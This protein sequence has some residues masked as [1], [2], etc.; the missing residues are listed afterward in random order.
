MFNRGTWRLLNFSK[1]ILKD[2]NALARSVS[3]KKLFDIKNFRL[4]DITKQELE[5]LKCLVK[6][7][8]NTFTE[9][10]EIQQLKKV[11]SNSEQKVT[12]T[13]SRVH[14]VKKEIEETKKKLH[15]ITY[16]YNHYLNKVER[17][18]EDNIK[19]EQ[20]TNTRAQYRKHVND[21]RQDYAGKMK[22][23]SAYLIGYQTN[24]TKLSEKETSWEWKTNLKGWGIYALTIMINMIISFYSR[25]RFMKLR[26]SND[27]TEKE[28]KDKYFIINLVSELS[29]YYEK[30]NELDSLGIDEDL[31]KATNESLQ[32]L[33]EDIPPTNISTLHENKQENSSSSSSSTSSIVTK[34]SM[35]STSENIK[36]SSKTQ[37]INNQSNLKQETPTTLESIETE[38]QE[39]EWIFPSSSTL[40]IP[41]I[42]VIAQI[43]GFV[44]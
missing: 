3:Y 44:L 13:M 16:D 34:S 30:I 40:Y 29:K 20:L 23:Q 25:K 26:A 10:D 38:V 31:Y 2:N 22:L 6:D 4:D 37:Y 5:H 41:L 24:L 8:I 15:D 27:I 12:E 35:E 7:Y 42:I 1:E 14:H 17:T 39:S 36:E 9:F 28:L 19:L 43:F 33:T 21:L 32:L 18:D 11:T